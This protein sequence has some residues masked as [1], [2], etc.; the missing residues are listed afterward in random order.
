MRRP[1]L[2]CP[3][4]RVQWIR[5]QEQTFDQQWLGSDQ[6]ARLTS[7]VGAAAQ[8]S[9]PCKLIFHKRHGAPQPSLVSLGIGWR[10]RSVRTPLPVRQVAAKH[11]Q[12]RSGKQL[13]E[14]DQQGRLTVASRSVREH[15]ESTAWMLGAVQKSAHRRFAPSFVD[16]LLYGLLLL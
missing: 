14:R 13:T 3:S 11:R 9:P 16:K 1:E 6:H 8:K 10:R 2:R 7:A 12:S 15:Q 5:Q 4:G